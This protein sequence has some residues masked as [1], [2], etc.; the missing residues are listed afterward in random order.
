M[1]HN[2]F[3][4]ILGLLLFS[5]L[6]LTIPFIV[7]QVKNRQETR[8]RA[9][10]GDAVRFYLVP[11]QQ[12]VGRDTTFD[13]DLW[14]D[15]KN[16][17]LSGIDVTLVVQDPLILEF[18][19]FQ[20]E[21]HGPGILDTQLIGTLGGIDATKAIFRYV[22]VQREDSVSVANQVKLGTLT[23]KAI[24]TQPNSVGR[25]VLQR[26]QVTGAGQTQSNGIPIQGEGSTLGQY[27]VSTTL[28]P[29]PTLPPGTTPSPTLP[30]G[31][32]PAPTSVPDRTLSLKLAL[33]GIGERSGPA[34]TRG[35]NKNPNSPYRQVEALLSDQ[36]NNPVPIS[37]PLRTTLT[38]NNSDEF[39]Y[40]A[41]NLATVPQGSYIVKL[42]VDKYLVRRAPGILSI[43]TGFVAQV[44][45]ILV[46]DIALNDNTI[47]VA[48][49]N[50]FLACFGSRS[51]NSTCPDSR[52]ADVN[53]DGF[54]DIVDGNYIVGNLSVRQGD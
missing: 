35:G 42:K 50:L 18:R 26:A 53:D 19:P 47:D 6:V 37:P 7:I 49:Y 40:G 13:V 41:I 30:P 44:P 12:T 27:P 45:D 15:T 54:V 51:P 24:A 48:D 17:A 5:A 21:S 43:P 25:V 20:G 38:F 29:T 4:S 52:V 39:F 2:L 14:L 1:N 36:N 16:Q 3:R 32:T 11:N 31:V 34:K 28:T 46:G 22:A 9:G 10:I 8:T 33:Q 23:L